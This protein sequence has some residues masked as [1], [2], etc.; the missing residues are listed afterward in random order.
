MTSYYLSVSA[1]LQC[2]RSLPSNW[3]S[4]KTSLIRKHLFLTQL[5]GEM[6]LTSCSKA[7]GSKSNDLV[8]V[9]TQIRR[10]GSMCHLRISIWHS[11]EGS[12]SVAHYPKVQRFRKCSAVSPSKWSKV[13]SAPENAH[14]QLSRSGVIYCSYKMVT[15]SMFHIHSQLTSLRKA[16]VKHNVDRQKIS[17]WSRITQ[18]SQLKLN[19]R[20]IYFTISWRVNT[21]H[22][23]NI[24]RDNL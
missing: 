14:L 1:P 8:A 10:V 12:K 18:R 5:T 7:P 2:H 24:D 22:T 19:K 13:L 11:V 20:T 3:F 4:T 15:Q 23:H 21:V 9:T 6:C 17:T 16:K